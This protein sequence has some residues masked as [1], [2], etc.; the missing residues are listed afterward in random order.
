MQK[1][2]IMSLL[3]NKGT[4]EAIMIKCRL[5]VLLAEHDMTQKE[6]SEKTGIQTN[7]ISKMCRN[8]IKQIPVSALNEIC[9]LFQC[10]PSDIFEHIKD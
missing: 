10:K 2:G 1:S 6:L 9:N 8:D 7:T 3:Y 4:Q 5:K